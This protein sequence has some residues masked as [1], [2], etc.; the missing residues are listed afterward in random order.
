MPRLFDAHVAALTCG[1]SS[2]KASSSTSNSRRIGGGCG[3]KSVSNY[4]A[5]GW[6][7]GRRGKHLSGRNSVWGGGLEAGFGEYSLGQD[8][9]SVAREQ[10][11][12]GH[13]EYSD[14]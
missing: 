8:E 6:V 14:A 5:S 9:Y 12:T 1:S 4:S 3:G 11:S 7:S 10:Y 13:K 2:G